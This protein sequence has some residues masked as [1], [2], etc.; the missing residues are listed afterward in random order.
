MVHAEDFQIV[1]VGGGIA[2][3]STAWFLRKEAR[4]RGMAAQVRILEAR[5]RAGGKV[6]TERPDGLV[7]E[8]GPDSM[9]REKPWG[10]ALCRELGLADDLLDCDVAR[11]KVALARGDGRLL[12]YPEGFRMGIPTR[13]GS[14]LTAGIPSWRGKLRMVRDLWMP[15]GAPE[16]DESVASFLRRRFG[17]EV[18]DDLAGP[19][20]SGI[21]TAD[22][23]R[24][25][26]LATFPRFRDLE[27]KHGSVIRGMR[28]A[29]G[30]RRGDP[31]AP[32]VSLRGGMQT[33]TDRIQSRLG[34]A[35]EMGCQVTA[36]TPTPAGWLIRSGD[37]E[38]RAQ[39]VV[40]AVPAPEAARLVAPFD[41]GLA[42]DLRR[43]RFVST[44][45]LTLAFRRRALPKPDMDAGFGFLVPRKAQ[46]AVTAG[47]WSG[48]K[49]PGRLPDPDLVLLRLFVGNDLTESVVALEDDALRAA[50]R[51]DLARLTGI[52]AEPTRVWIH[53]WPQGNPQYDVGHLDQVDQWMAAARVHPGLYLT[54][55][56]YRGLSLPDV[57]R[58][59]EA[60]AK[61]VV[62]AGLRKSDAS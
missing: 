1:I 15:D 16:G 38:V 30:A 31:P 59:A 20:M 34:T 13:G 7:I 8:G 55:S 4:A 50:A 26:L 53:R 58:Q 47:T 22:P 14:L 27:R 32:F 19:M 9:F 54:G 6:V 36:L 61:E 45:N 49:F 23:E 35:P 56:S 37:M 12:P 62:D 46:R 43:L 18:V 40:L 42:T 29:A 17:Q 2:G 33:L 28:T 51:E 5:D 25:S 21:Y 39:A 3:L 60:T 44:A 24:L 48:T 41:A 52:R 11:M 57:V 10:L